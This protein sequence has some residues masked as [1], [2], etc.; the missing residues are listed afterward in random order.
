MSL[1][2]VHHLPAGNKPWS[3]C[4]VTLPPGE[5]R[6]RKRPDLGGGWGLCLCPD[7]LRRLTRPGPRRRAGQTPASPALS[8]DTRAG[9]QT[10]RWSGSAGA[11]TVRRRHAEA[12]RGSACSRK[13]A[14]AGADL[15]PTSA[16]P[17]RSADSRLFPLPG[18]AL[19]SA[20]DGPAA[21]WAQYLVENEL[22]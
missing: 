13:D 20:L 16:Q 14:E 4:S 7:G 6:K 12:Q 11:V 3:Y 22:P 2:E 17:P 9:S 1:L 19:S 21:T 5:Q 15:G 18:E 8:G 10:L